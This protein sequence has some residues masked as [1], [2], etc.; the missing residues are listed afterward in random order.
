VPLRGA[1]RRRRAVLLTYLGMPD[2]PDVRSV[3]RHL[4]RILGDPE[5]TPLPRGL[6]W[7]NPILG[8][9]LARFRA[10]P[11][12]GIYQ[13]IW[14]DGVSPHRTVAQQQMS[15]LQS[16][17]PG[18]MRVFCAMRY[19]RPGI[20]ETL[21]RIASL[22]IE[23]LIVVSMYPQ[24]SATTT[25]T[26][27][28]EFYRQLKR[29]KCRIDVTMRSIWYDDAGYI[30]AQARLIHEYATSKGLTPENT[31]LVYSAHSLP[32]SCL[33]RGDPYPQQIRRTAQLVTRRLGWPSARTSLT[34]Q[35]HPGAGAGLRP[36]TSD[37]LADLS[38]AGQRQV[39]VCPLSFTTDC[40][41]TLD[42]IQTRYRRDFEQEGGRFFA[43]PPLNAFEPFVTALK[44]LALHGRHTICPQDI[45]PSLLA[46]GRGPDPSHEETEV[47]IDSLVMVGMSLTG[48]LDCRQGPLLAHANAEQFRRI[49]KPRCDVPD[50]LRAVCDGET[51]REALLWNT[52]RRFEFYGWLKSP[53]DDAQRAEIVADIS[54]Q[55]F[56][57]NGHV[58]APAV[59]VLH[60]A[61]AWHHLMRTAAGLNSGLPGEREVLEQLQVAQRLAERA[62]TG[63]PLTDRLLAHVCDHERRLREQTEWSRYQPDHCYASI[64]RIVRSIGLDLPACRCAVI[65]GST[66]SCGILDALADRFDVPRRQMTLLHRG[67]GHGGH[68][69]MLRKAVGNGRRIR[70]NKYDEA[71]AIRAIADADAVFFGLDRNAPV[72][73][74]EQI[75]ELRDFSA[76]PLTIFDFNLFGSTTG[77]EALDGV[78]LWTADD[79]EA[80]AAEYAR[81]LCAGERFARAAE[82]A[83]LWIRDHV[84][85]SPAADRMCPG[86]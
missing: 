17:L 59:N 73:T 32:A 79:L 62:G 43:C 53:A 71:A 40:L 24:Y 64:S 54:G 25:L 42:Q 35:S 50:M 52:C 81:E 16:S 74:A 26:T 5:V 11:I 6:G 61:D 18:Q 48:R 85:T 33:E 23:E 77:M 51:V 76:R 22:G 1:I 58:D 29:H 45:A 4:A 69:K 2:A 67:H 60:G 10:A 84:P 68:L 27:V 34:F 38:H 86:R 39:L 31:H 55:L 57:H 49:K 15:A 78:R 20:A 83:A 21:Q 8:R 19:G 65:G 30:N 72:L 56:N 3:R 12:A 13:S 7:L 46:A 82:A 47:P 9:A 14:T 44:N 80:A 28:R 70:V 36:T 37:V 75:R 63:G 41:E 66:T